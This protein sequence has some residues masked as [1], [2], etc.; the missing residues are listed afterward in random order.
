MS[1]YKLC[2]NNKVEYKGDKMKIVCIGHAAYDITIPVEGYPLENTKNRVANRIECGGGPACNAA[3]LLGC[4][5]S[6]VEFI[7]VVGNDLYGKKIKEELEH[8]HVKTGH[9]Q[10]NENYETT[11]SFIIANT[12]IGSRTILTY[13]P[14]EMEWSGNLLLDKPDVI[15]IDGQEYELSKKILKENPDAISIIDAGRPVDEVIELSHMVSYLVC[16]HEFAESLTNTTLKHATKETLESCF[17]KME[18]IF[19]NHIIITLESTGSLYRD[20]DTIKLMPA[21]KVKAVDSTGAG[22]LFH[23]AFTYAISKKL[24]IEKVMQIATVAGGISVT[25]L[26]GRNSVATKEEMRSYIHDFE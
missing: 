26:G 17:I 8:A 23:G 6:D 3:Y 20:K 24:P 11:S 14:H 15:L 13:R 9:M 25:K 7:G 2:Y 22:D 19:K 12:E 21:I 4:W 5:G 1:Y 16:S 18:E 10:L